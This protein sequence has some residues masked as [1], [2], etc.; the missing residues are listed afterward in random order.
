MERD[1]ARTMRRHARGSLGTCGLA[2]RRTPRGGRS[3]RK[4]RLNVPTRRALHAVELPEHSGSRFRRLR[5]EA[6]G[7]FGHRIDLWCQVF[8]DRNA[9]E[10]NSHG[11]ALST[12]DA[13]L[14]AIVLGF[15]PAVFPVAWR[16][17][18]C[19]HHAAAVTA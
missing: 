18:V 17:T 13:A 3:A 15:S 2:G 10:E 12:R 16:V 7:S 19:H 5:G 1:P 9:L 14:A 11:P 8:G 4:F 6:D